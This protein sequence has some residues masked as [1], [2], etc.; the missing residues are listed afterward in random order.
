[1]SDSHRVGDLEI[2]PDLN[3]Q[4]RSWAM[5]RFAWVVLALF[6]LAAL[7]GLFGPGPLSQTRAEQ[8][9]SPL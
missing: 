1:M 8:Q 6:I 5:Q 4:R 9:D 7:L 2:S 3:F